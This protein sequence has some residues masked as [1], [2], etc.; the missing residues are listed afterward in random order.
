VTVTPSIVSAIVEKTSAPLAHM[1]SWMAGFWVL[2]AAV[3]TGAIRLLSEWQR[4][5]TLM[6]VVRHAPGGTVVVQERGLGG[7]VMW[8]Q[9]GY[10]LPWSMVLQPD[11]TKPDVR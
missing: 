2:G 10:G 5:L 1:T 11:I 4:R 9:V 3:V 8:I 6:A 7:P